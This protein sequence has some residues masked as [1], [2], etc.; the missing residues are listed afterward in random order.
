MAPANLELDGHTPRG[1]G[2]NSCLRSSHD[3]SLA[4]CTRPRRVSTRRPTCLLLEISM[5]WRRTLLVRGISMGLAG[6]TLLR[7]FATPDLRSARDA[8]NGDQVFSMTRHEIPEEQ[9]CRS[10]RSANIYAQPPMPSSRRRCIHPT[11]TTIRSDDQCCCA[12]VAVW[13]CLWPTLSSRQAR[14]RN[15]TLTNADIVVLV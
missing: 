2:G 12:P 3:W 8:L 6:R 4:R 9:G 15:C 1:V 14:L 13:P 11:W 7:L 10:R 5:A